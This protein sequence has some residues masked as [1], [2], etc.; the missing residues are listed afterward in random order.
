VPDKF[1]LGLLSSLLQ[2]YLNISNKIV[3]FEYFT[4]TG[5]DEGVSGEEWCEIGVNI[6]PFRYCLKYL[7]LETEIV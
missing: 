4:A 5:C 3:W 2:I 6:Q 1:I 7:K